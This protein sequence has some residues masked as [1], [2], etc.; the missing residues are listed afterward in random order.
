MATKFKVKAA[1]IDL[2]GTLLDTL[3]DIAEAAD[4]MLRE[5]GRPA[6]GQ[7]VVRDYIGNG[8]PRLV[9]RLLTGTLE[10]EPDAADFERGHRA[11]EKHYRDTFL[12]E[13]RPYPGVVDGLQRMRAQGL[14]LACVTNKAEAFT[15]PL[16]EHCGLMSFFGVVV[17]GDTLPEKKPHPLPLRH[18]AERFGVAVEQVLVIGDSHNDA[19]AARAAGCPVVCVPYG[20]RGGRDVRELDCDAIVSDLIEAAGLVA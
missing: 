3:P 11:F 15:V 5:L 6:A 7:A 2:D 8:I 17:G 10:G 20:Y 1:A 9:K 18:V 13:S 19:E 4:R 14:Q 12:I 16:L